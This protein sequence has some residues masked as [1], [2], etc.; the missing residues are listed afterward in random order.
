MELRP[1]SLGDAEAWDAFC[2]GAINATLLHARKFLSYHGERFQDRSLLLTHE[3]A[4][5]GVLPAALDP[6][7]DR[8]VVS[9]PGVT[10]GGWVHQG[11][12]TGTRM[13]EAFALAEAHYAA[14]GA[15]IL[16]YKCVP[17]IYHRAPADDD[18]WALSQRKAVRVRCDL[19]CAVD[20]DHRLPLSERR[21]RSAKK[22]AKAVSLSSDWGLLPQLH[23][24]V[25]AQ[26][27]ARHGARIVH[28]VAELELLHGR[29]PQQ[30]LLRAALVEGK[31]EAGYFLFASPTVW[32]SQYSG[33]SETGRELS[34]LDAVTLA[35]MDEAA[36]AGIRYFDFGISNEAQGTV[37][38]EGLFRY[39]AEFGGAGVAHEFYTLELAR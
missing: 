24:V 31:V 25:G 3:G 28:S 15:R 1:Y 26:L 2:D 37:L 32:H 36:A 16:R 30:V 21:K 12:L 18:L 13:V 8:Q 29:F 4:L 19:S 14:Q 38:N 6:D 9:H 33:S 39:K 5:V 11:W 20:L 27:Q 34:A 23:A 35:A 17:G 10:Y 22:A 7:D